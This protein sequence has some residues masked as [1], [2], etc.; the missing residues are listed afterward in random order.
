MFP[1][2]HSMEEENRALRAQLKRAVEVFTPQAPSESKELIQRALDDA[3]SRLKT[4]EEESP[5]R[6]F[7]AIQVNATIHALERK[8]EQWVEYDASVQFLLHMVASMQEVNVDELKD[9]IR[10]RVNS[11]MADIRNHSISTR[12]LFNHAFMQSGLNDELQ[13]DDKA[14]LEYWAR[15]IRRHLLRAGSADGP[16]PN[17]SDLAREIPLVNG[18]AP[19]TLQIWT[20]FLETLSH[21]MQHAT[22]YGDADARAI[23]VKKRVED[24]FD[25]AEQKH[26]KTLADMLH[27]V[28]RNK[29]VAFNASEAIDRLK[30]AFRVHI[31]NMGSVD[32]PFPSPAIVAFFVSV[33]NLSLKNRREVWKRF[34]K[35]VKSQ[36]VVVDLITPPASPR[37]QPQSPTGS[38]ATLESQLD[39]IVREK[40][41]LEL[42][43][44]EMDEGADKA[45]M[46]LHK[47]NLTSQYRTLLQQL[48]V[49]KQQKQAEERA[50]REQEE[51]Q[52]EQ[53]RKREAEDLKTQLRAIA[54]DKEAL[55]REM[56]DMIDYADMDAASSRY[57]ELEAQSKKLLAQLDKLQRRDNPLPPQ[58][59]KMA[60]RIK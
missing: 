31:L 45:A 48:R 13:Y 51:A 30:K 60:R 1:I 29:D 19:R 4:L 28:L 52:R 35:L 3:R 9:A 58:N 41:G 46:I 42:E 10:A 25:E 34:L 49:A 2:T 24:Y 56:R 16:F 26:G 11:Y 15:T 32:A 12:Y 55:D 17:A 18:N 7:D 20:M 54:A 27:Y 6:E 44:I 33:G 47:D 8:R 43:L 5:E 14:F 50:Q 38:I 53:A 57:D 37:P 23:A 59:K 36:P 22:Q 21:A 40:Q 39:S